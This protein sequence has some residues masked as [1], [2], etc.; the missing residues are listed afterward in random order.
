[1]LLLAVAGLAHAAEPFHLVGAVAQKAF[2]C[3]D[4]QD[5]VI[6]GSS[7]TLT[8]QGS[9]GKLQIVGSTNTITV[10]GVT[11]VSVEGAQNSVT[12]TRN[13]SGEKK[14][15]VTSVGAGNKVKAL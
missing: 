12:F 5:I 15:P 6:E 2:R 3:E 13:L 14:L 8:F 7:L 9:C 1:M 11:S 4:G 10:D